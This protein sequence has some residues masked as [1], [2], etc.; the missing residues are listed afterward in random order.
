MKEPNYLMRMMDTGGRLLAD[1]TCKDTV[2]R[3]KENVENV[4]KKF[5]YKL[6]FDRHF[7]TAMQL[8]PTTTSGMHCYQLRRHGWLIGVCV[9][10]LLLF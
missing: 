7:L 5:K 4:V 6:P 8:T 3:W 2:R 1:E 9:G 10:Y